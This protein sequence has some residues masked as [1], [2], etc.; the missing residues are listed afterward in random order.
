[1][2]GIINRSCSPLVCNERNGSFCNK[3]SCPRERRENSLELWEP[4]SE[5]CDE[6]ETI[7]EH[8]RV[9][10]SI[11]GVR[12]GDERNSQRMEKS[13]REGDVSGSL[14]KLKYKRFLCNCEGV[15]EDLIEGLVAAD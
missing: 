7:D 13:D 12:A 14:F 10:D 5:R 4:S 15:A 3:S 1:M 9:A 8:H 2:L 11:H 6:H